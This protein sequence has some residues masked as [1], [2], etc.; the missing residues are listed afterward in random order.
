M[1]SF[2]RAER[3]QAGKALR[4]KVPRASHASWQGGAN[5]R[6]PVALIEESSRG[7]IPELIPNAAFGRNQK[8]VHYNDNT[9]AL[10][11]SVC[12]AHY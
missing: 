4:E 12:A 6:D 3:L 9:F 1:P 11:I 5:G 2:S 10:E 7:R 8:A